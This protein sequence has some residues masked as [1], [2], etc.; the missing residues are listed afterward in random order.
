M[1]RV[2]EKAQTYCDNSKMESQY[3]ECNGQEVSRET[4]SNL[5]ACIGD[6]F[7]AGNGTTTFNVPDET[8]YPAN[9][10]IWIRFKSP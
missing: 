7:G 8:P 5:Y 4:Y 6:T 2:A 1:S 10:T 9:T 3:L